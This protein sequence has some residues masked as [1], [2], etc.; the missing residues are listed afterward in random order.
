MVLSGS[1]HLR[2]PLASL[3]FPFSSFFFSS[4]APAPA[5]PL[6]AF[7]HSAGQAL[8]LLQCREA[9]CVSGA[10]W[11]NNLLTAGTHDRFE[12]DVA[13]VVAPNGGAHVLYRR[14]FPGH[15]QSQAALLQCDHPQAPHGCVVHLL[16]T[17]QDQGGHI[18]PDSLALLPDA[19]LVALWRTGGS[20][21]ATRAS[22]SMYYGLCPAL[23][24][25]CKP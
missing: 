16:A 12:G 6:L 17:G 2:Y 7:L 4:V 19:R 15:E 21:P 3:P 14:V 5:G 8:H 18:G 1:P 20:L 22:A 25:K 23:P 10:L 9:T 24:T 13:L 11:R